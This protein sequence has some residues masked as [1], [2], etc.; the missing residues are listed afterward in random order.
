[1]NIKP[2]MILAG[3]GIMAGI[4]SVI[5]YNEKPAPQ[6]PVSVSYNPYEKGIYATGIT[7]SYQTN[8]SN[9]N[10]YPE[11]SG[12]V[13]D[14]LVQNGEI[15]KAGKPLFFID[16]SIQEQMVNKDLAQIKYAK[17]SLVNVQDQLEKIQAAYQLNQKSVSKNSADN[18]INAVE[19]AKANLDVAK[20][21]YQVDKALLDKYVIYSPIDG[22]ILRMGTTEGDYVSPSGIY[23]TY[24][25]VM[26][27][28]VQIATNLPYLQ[29]RCF[30][31]EILVPHLPVAEKLE[32]TLFIR[33]GSTKGIPLEF[34]NLQ[35]YTEPKIQLSDQR[36]ERVD[37]RVLPIIFKFKKPTD[38]NIFPGQLV[39]IYIKGKK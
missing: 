34:V 24:T 32:A 38:E 20:T 31:D 22:I 1:M 9:I 25:Q 39:D 21:Q 17:A 26:L 15:V 3:L 36:L 7:E 2:L 16:S 37:V 12:R 4:A 11:V 33:G 5:I 19:I 8:A 23:D 29:V 35:P 6:P 30:V 10:I 28:A 13:T 14:T 18:A 27:P